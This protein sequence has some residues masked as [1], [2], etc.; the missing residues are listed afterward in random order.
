M[1]SRFAAQRLHNTLQHLLILGGMSLLLSVPAWLLAGGTGVVWAFGLVLLT[2][3]LSGRVPARLVLANA[4]AGVLHRHHAPQLYRVMDLLYRRAG[5]SQPPWLF[6]VPSKD[7]NAF[8]VGDARDGGIAVTEGLLRRLSLRQLAGVLAHEVSHLR[9]GDTRV[10]S[11]AATM[12]RLT[13]WGAFLVQLALIAMLP[14][15]MAGE[16]RLP[17]LELLAVGLAPTASTLL[18]L[19]LSRNREF[20]ADMEAAALTRDPEGLA[21]ALGVLEAHN[22]LWLTTLFGRRQLPGWLRFLQTHPATEERVGRLMAL[23]RRQGPRPPSSRP[24]RPREPLVEARPERRGHRYWL[25]RP[26]DRR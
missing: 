25:G 26:D 8:A 4:G 15:V 17:W 16:I 24:Y 11:M 12:T 13:V 10:M 18:Q 9:H 1:L 5:L 3:Y 20:T 23:A 22:G 14:M 7:L 2:L 19:A 21:D 6:Y